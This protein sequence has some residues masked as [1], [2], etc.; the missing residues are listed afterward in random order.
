MYLISKHVS[1]LSDVSLTEPTIT[2]L[3]THNDFVNLSKLIQRQKNNIDT[4]QSIHDQT[5]ADNISTEEL[6]LYQFTFTPRT[7]SCKKANDDDDLFE[8]LFR[9][10]LLTIR[11]IDIPKHPIRHIDF[12]DFLRSHATPTCD[13]IF[14]ESQI[15]E[16][17]NLITIKNQKARCDLWNLNALIKLLGSKY[18]E[19]MSKFEGFSN[20]NH[21]FNSIEN[22][23]QFIHTPTSTTLLPPFHFY[24]LIAHFN[25][26]SNWVTN[27]P[28]ANETKP[29]EI[30]N[31]IKNKHESL[32]FHAEDFPFHSTYSYIILQNLYLS[33]CKFD[34][35]D[36]FQ[37]E[38][39]SRLNN[40]I[41]QV[42]END[43]FDIIN[44]YLR[45]INFHSYNISDKYFD[46]LSFLFRVK[47]TPWASLLMI[48]KILSSAIYQNRLC[49][50]IHR[51]PVNIENDILFLL[52]ANAHPKDF[53]LVLVYIQTFFGTDVNLN[54]KSGVFSKQFNDLQ[55]T[56]DKLKSFEEQLCK[57]IYVEKRLM[58]QVLTFK[59]PPK[60]NVDEEKK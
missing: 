37:S 40:V 42:F 32:L 3:L 20:E 5:Q 14:L 36:I 8:N 51:E 10:I 55:S 60:N 50:Q 28:L 34:L 48:T 41:S 31:V 43:R 16:L 58:A 47:P 24:Y 9:D 27:N 18:Q 49:T 21:V 56:I 44:D 54:D 17:E 15:K 53:H 46:Q 6:K 26:I 29:D 23:L 52:F 30:N 12:F 11:P 57:S 13:R 39:T 33:K 19:R 25:F 2:S 22:D 35:N 1:T 38:A 7:Q 4:N 45:I 59:P